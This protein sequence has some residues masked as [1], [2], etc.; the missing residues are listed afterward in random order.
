MERPGIIFQ[1]ISYARFE[2]YHFEVIF[3]PHRSVPP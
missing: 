3:G 1:F 2:E